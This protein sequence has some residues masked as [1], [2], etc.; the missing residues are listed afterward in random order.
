MAAFI[1]G[2]IV[3][4]P[5]PF[6]VGTGS[7][8]RPALVVASWPFADGTDFLLCLISSQAVSDPYI[9]KLEA[10]DIQGGTLSRQ[11]YVRPSYLFAVD[12]GLIVYKVG[13]LANDRLT[14]VVEKII[15]V[16]Q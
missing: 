1:K 15:S 14:Q 6:S 7:K 4:V 10:G 16:L 13:A 9:M 5:F 11:S 12:E 2:D 8:R 3:V